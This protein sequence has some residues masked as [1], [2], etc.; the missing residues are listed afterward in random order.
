VPPL[1]S[2]V[3]TLISHPYLLEPLTTCA[4]LTLLKDELLFWW[5]VVQ[6]YFVLIF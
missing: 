2:S 3:L 1:L 4:A 5:Y 6:Y